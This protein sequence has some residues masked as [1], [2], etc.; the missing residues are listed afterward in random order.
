MEF[1]NTI[2]GVQINAFKYSIIIASLKETGIVP[3]NS[4]IVINKCPLPLPP[5]LAQPSTPPQSD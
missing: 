4:L 3:F 1:L 2:H 5:P